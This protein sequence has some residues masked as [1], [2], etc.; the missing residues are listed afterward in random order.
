MDALLLRSWRPF[1][2]YRSFCLP[3]S[4]RDLK[5]RL[6]E[7][8]KFYAANYAFVLCFI[9]LIECLLYS[10]FLVFLCIVGVL[11]GAWFS[12]SDLPLHVGSVLITPTHKSLIGVILGLLAMYLT[13]SAKPLMYVSFCWFGIVL[14]HSAFRRRTAVVVSSPSS[15]SLGTSARR[16]PTK[17]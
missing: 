6:K 8:P 17:D 15:G 16:T 12:F 2:D 10:P 7:N 5:D 9:C 13:G 11:F 14:L 3:S 4:L 1:L